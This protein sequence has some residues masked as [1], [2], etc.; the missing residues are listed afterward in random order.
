MTGRPGS[1]KSTFAARVVSEHRGRAHGFLSSEVRKD[2]RRHGF[3][4]TDLDSG[5]QGIL[6]SPDIIGEP[7]FGA[8]RPDGSRRLG[9][10]LSFLEDVICQSLKAMPVDCR[11]IV[12]DEIGPMQARSA[13]FRDVIHELF[14]HPPVSIV[15]TLA[16]QTTDP[17]LEDLRSTR[18]AATVF[19]DERNRDL[20]AHA[21]VPVLANPDDAR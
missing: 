5:N 13:V 6:A 18:T 7:R 3:V 14:S 4:L 1:G 11:L 9:I 19:I 10:D 2:G 12:L 21:L 20:L 17:W 16:M 8:L 15:A